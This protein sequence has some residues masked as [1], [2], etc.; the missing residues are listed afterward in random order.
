MKKLFLNILILGLLAAIISV[1]ISWFFPIYWGDNIQLTKINYYKKNPNQY[2]ALFFGGSLE[3]RHVSPE[4]IKSELAKKQIRFNGFNF[5]VDSHNFTQAITEAD[6]VYDNYKNDSLKYIF[7]S[8]STEAYLSYQNLHTNKLICWMKAS[9]IYKLLRILYYQ[10]DDLSF[11]LFCAGG[12]LTSWGEN[13][14][15]FG[16]LKDKIKYI[17]IKNNIDTISLG[18]NLDGFVPLELNE[19]GQVAN[20]ETEISKYVLMVSTIEYKKRADSAN[21]FND[22]IFKTYFNSNLHAKDKD[23]DYLYSLCDNMIKKY[24]SKGVKV[25]FYLPARVPFGYKQQITVYNRLPEQNKFDLANPKKYPEF[26][27]TKYGF[28]NFH[29]NKPGAEMY[30]YQF[31][32]ELSKLIS[33]E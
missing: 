21:W 27:E 11:R 9:T 33:S 10:T 19:K 26:Y 15:N 31:A 17:N 8:L 28:D 5:G 16:K 22:T 20:P 4:I 32:K 1:F 14:F 25:Y 29:L 23:V 6:Y 12:Y 3:Y 18:K 30:S 7:I 2:N 24:A 13:A